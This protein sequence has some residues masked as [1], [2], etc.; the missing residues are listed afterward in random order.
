MSGLCI[1]HK[2][3]PCY[4]LSKNEKKKALFHCW[5]HISDVVGASPMVGGHPG[6][7]VAY[8]V[9]IVELEDGSVKEVEPTYIVF[10][11]S[12]FVDYAW[13]NEKGE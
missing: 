6:G 10:I 12:P 8:P 2:L 11:D 7:T 3:R 5:S 1:E 13:D 4:I 9:G